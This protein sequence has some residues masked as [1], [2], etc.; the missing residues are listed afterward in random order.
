MKRN[1]PE[2]IRKS[3]EEAVSNYRRL[4]DPELSERLARLAELVI[5]TIAGGHR[6]YF[7][8]NGGSAADAQHLAAEFVGR[9]RMERRGLPAASLTTD[10]S[11]ITAVGNDYGFNQ[12]FSRQVEALGRRGDLLFV[13]STS[14][15]SD[16]LLAENRR[17][18]GQGRRPPQGRG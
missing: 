6:V 16:N 4:S 15:N 1:W 13:F 11:V 9:F 17:S 12:V 2:K 18:A 7:C 3:I 8:G 14:G 5:E 10:T